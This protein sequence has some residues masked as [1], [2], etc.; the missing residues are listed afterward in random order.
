[1]EVSF[2]LAPGPSLRTTL[3]RA[4]SKRKSR[5]W[6]ESTNCPAPASS[7][8]SR[9][10]LAPRGTA[11]CRPP[12]L[13]RSRPP[14]GR[15]PYPTW[16]GASRSPRASQPQNG[17]W[18]ATT[19]RLP[20]DCLRRGLTL[21]KILDTCVCHRLP[22]PCTLSPHQFPRP[23]MSSS[24]PPAGPGLGSRRKTCWTMTRTTS[25]P[26]TFH[27]RQTQAQ[28]VVAALLM[29][30]GPSQTCLS[31]P[32]LRR[33]ARYLAKRSSLLMSLPSSASMHRLTWGTATISSVSHPENCRLQCS[34]VTTTKQQRD[35]E[36]PVRNHSRSA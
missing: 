26:S 25:C 20:L 8:R 11:G 6:E 28:G 4:C 9:A 2:L 30:T 13:R 7:W 35:D 16:L 33:R 34:T 29:P 18:K 15:A 31:P 19:L 10:G 21:G 32:G 24:T 36:G 22:V 1:M 3:S 17:V 23:R 14:Q 5:R 27:S 12:A